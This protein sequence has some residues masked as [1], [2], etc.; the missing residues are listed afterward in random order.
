M[1]IVSL[2]IGILATSGASFLAYWLMEQHGL[3]T[4]GFSLRDHDFTL[5]GVN[6]VVWVTV[7]LGLLVAALTVFTLKAKPGIIWRAFMEDP[8][9]LQVCGCDP[10]KIRAASWFIAHGLAASLGSLISIH[11]QGYASMG[12]MHL[13]VMAL[14]SLL[15]GGTILGSL[16]AGLGLAGFTSIVFGSGG[17]IYGDVFYYE[18]KFAAHPLL[19]W[20]ALG[21]EG[22]IDRLY[23]GVTRSEE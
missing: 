8:S 11:G 12:H 1:T 14:A 19:I 17:L 5:N 10:G 7:L 21:F 20:G 18:L 4:M 22:R 15:G 3:Y 6:G 9:L 16:L 23:E 13:S 2:G